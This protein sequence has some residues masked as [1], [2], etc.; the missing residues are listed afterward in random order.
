MAAQYRTIN[1]GGGSIYEKLREKGI[2]PLDYIRFYHLRA[3]D[4]INAPWDSFISKMEQNSGVKFHEAQVALA[5]QWIG[6]D[7]ASNQKEVTLAIPE[8]T[9]EALVQSEKTPIRTETVPIPQ[10]SEEAR[11]IVRKFESGAEGL[12]GDQEVS[13]TVAQHMLCDRTELIDEKWFGTEEEELNA[14]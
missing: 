14:L 7:S 8:A 3:Y 4:R 12:R 5:R 11:E 13:D 10:S 6:Q 2:E 1:R 9:N